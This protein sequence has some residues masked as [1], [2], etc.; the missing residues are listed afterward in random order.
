MLYNVQLDDISWDTEVDGVIEEVEDLPTSYFVDDI[1]A[2]SEEDAIDHAVDHV[3][4]IFGYCIFDSLTSV[5]IV[6][7]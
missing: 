7:E 2:D 4:E 3:T 6:G 5:T 1:E